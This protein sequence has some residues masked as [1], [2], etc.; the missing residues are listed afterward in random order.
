MAAQDLVS[1]LPCTCLCFAFPFHTHIL[2]AL[3]SLSLRFRIPPA[4]SPIHRH[5]RWSLR[6]SHSTHAES[7]CPPALL[8]CCCHCPCCSLASSSPCPLHA[9]A[10]PLQAAPK[11]FHCYPS[12]HAFLATCITHIRNRRACLRRSIYSTLGPA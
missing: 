5:D 9:S 7:R 8:A 11:H 4:P 3:F 12:S 1:L 2:S 10:A 6:K